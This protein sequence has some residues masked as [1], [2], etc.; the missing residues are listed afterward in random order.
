MLNIFFLQIYSLHFSFPSLFSLQNE[1]VKHRPTW[2][3]GTPLPRHRLPPWSWPHPFPLP[4]F[5][6]SL[7][8]KMDPMVTQS[9]DSAFW[10]DYYDRSDMQTPV[11]LMNSSGGPIVPSSFYPTVPAPECG[12]MNYRYN[13]PTAVVCGIS[14]IFGIIFNF[15]GKDKLLALI[16]RRWLRPTCKL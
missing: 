4:L 6:T 10:D 13:V 1:A 14:F 16:F 3:V 7:S 11:D 12:A 9:S 2:S 5:I 15:F 8:T